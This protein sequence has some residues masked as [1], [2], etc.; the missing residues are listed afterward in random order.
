MMPAL[1]PV[2]K[3]FLSDR[4]GEL[5]GI[6][7]SATSLASAVI[8]L[9]AAGGKRLRSAFAYWGWR[10]A[11]ATQPPDHPASPTP[12]QRSWPARRSRCCTRSRSCT[13][14]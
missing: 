3:T 11:T 14:T 2:L 5:E 6:D 13:T 10:T 1:E 9:V 8:D 4:R 7:Q 12:R